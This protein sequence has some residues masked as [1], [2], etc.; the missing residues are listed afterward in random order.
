MFSNHESAAAAAQGKVI[1]CFDYDKNLITRHLNKGDA[2]VPRAGVEV[3]FNHTADSP[4]AIVTF[5]SL[6]NI[7]TIFNTANDLDDSLK[8]FQKAP[9]VEKIYYTVYLK[10][11]QT[12]ATHLTKQNFYYC[13]T[14][15]DPAKILPDF[16]VF[17][18]PNRGPARD[19]AMAGALKPK[20]GG[21]YISHGKNHMIAKAVELS[22]ADS[23]ELYDDS[24]ENCE[25]AIASFDACPLG[26]FKSTQ[27]TEENLGFAIEEG[28]P[29]TNSVAAANN[30]IAECDA[31]IFRK[32]FGRKGENHEVLAVKLFKRELERWLGDPDSTPPIMLPDGYEEAAHGAANLCKRVNAFLTAP[33][34]QNPEFFARVERRVE[35]DLVQ[36]IMREFFDKPLTSNQTSLLSWFQTGSAPAAPAE[37]LRVLMSKVSTQEAKQHAVE[38]VLQALQTV[39]DSHT[40]TPG[41]KAVQARLQA[42]AQK[43]ETTAAVAVGSETQTDDAPFSDQKNA[44]PSETDPLLGQSNAQEEGIASAPELYEVVEPEERAPKSD[45]NRINIPSGVFM[46]VGGIALLAGMAHAAATL[47]V[48]GALTASTGVGAIPGA[49][50]A[51]LGLL[52]LA[53]TAAIRFCCMKDKVK[54]LEGAAAEE[55]NKPKQGYTRV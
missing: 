48:A 14:W 36:E 25:R 44:G 49:A 34:A 50:I 5:N 30:L 17:C 13:Q 35:V 6:E 23:A 20:D 19:L 42:Y 1:K 24:K 53:V 33:D 18:L 45:L 2:A 22:G 41:C 51:L 11:G 32:A 7:D 52:L 28:F 55:Y 54:G 47:A 40:L 31:Y 16:R 27:P 9:A 26:I 39:A 15:T 46:T 3:K 8:S 38:N 10:P 29:K 4:A 12:Q 37:Q 43:L 21:K